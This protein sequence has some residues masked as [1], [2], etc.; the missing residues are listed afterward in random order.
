MSTRAALRTDDSAAGRSRVARASWMLAT[1]RYPVMRASLPAVHRVLPS[2][3]THLRR[4]SS[5]EPAHGHCDRYSAPFGAP[6]AITSDR[7]APARP[8]RPP[9]RGLRPRTRRASRCSG[10]VARTG[11]PKT[12]VYRT[13]E[14]VG[15]W[16]GSSATSGRYAI[17]T[18][19]FERATLAGG[20]LALRDAALPFL[21]EVCGPPAR[22]RTS[23]SSTEPRS[24]TSRSWSAAARWHPEPSRRTDAAAVHRLGKALIAFS[25]PE[26]GEQVIESGLAART[27]N[28]LTSRGPAQQ[29]ARVRGGGHRF[30]P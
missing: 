9:P 23:P 6:V 14:D 10:L 5:R 16:A 24:C 4:D 18:R 2:I 17:G 1:C 30:R 12:T 13:G 29:L 22:P 15:P 8:R 21:Q 20:R 7:P 26:L 3:A 28:T 27:P 19:L 25:P 11:L